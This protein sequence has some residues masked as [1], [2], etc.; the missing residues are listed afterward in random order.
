MLLVQIKKKLHV[1]RAE[2]KRKVPLQPKFFSEHFSGL[3]K[4]DKD[5]TVYLQCGV[6][7]E[8]SSGCSV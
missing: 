8:G 6:G 5:C 4:S 2:S 3:E 7:L 1:Q